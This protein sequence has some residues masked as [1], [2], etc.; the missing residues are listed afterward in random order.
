MCR[1]CRATQEL[2]VFFYDPVQLS[3]VSIHQV[4]A[5]GVIKVE[6]LP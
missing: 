5:P 3:A 6:L 1:V 4:R 2:T